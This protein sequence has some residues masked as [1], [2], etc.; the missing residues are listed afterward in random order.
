MTKPQALI[1]FN[2]SAINA[3][4]QHFFSPQ[5]PQSNYTLNIY[6]QNSLSGNLASRP[7]FGLFLLQEAALACIG[8]NKYESPAFIIQKYD[9]T[10]FYGPIHYIY[11]IVDF[12]KVI[13]LDTEMSVSAGEQCCH[14]ARPCKFSLFQICDFFL[15][16]KNA[17]DITRP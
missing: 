7:F 11:V 1:T 9:L 6:S 10:A 12:K 13:A 17:S 8:Y 16:M 3:F 15:L 5:G 4:F 14:P 2:K